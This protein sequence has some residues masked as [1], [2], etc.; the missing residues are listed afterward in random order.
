MIVLALSLAYNTEEHSLVSSDVTFASCGA[1]RLIA[2][3]VGEVE[4]HDRR[5]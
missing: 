5:P 3:P 1:G 4:W 2:V